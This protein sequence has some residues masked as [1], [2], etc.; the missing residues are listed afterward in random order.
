MVEFNIN[1]LGI[2]QNEIC[3]LAPWWVHI[4]GLTRKLIV[5]LPD[6]SFDGPSLAPFDRDRDNFWYKLSKIVLTEASPNLYI[7]RLR[8]SGEILDEL[9]NA[10]VDISKLTKK[11]FL[12]ECNSIYINKANGLE[13]LQE[14]F[15]EL[16]KR[17]NLNID[18]SKMLKE[19]YQSFFES[20]QKR[21]E[22]LIKDGVEYAGDIAIFKKVFQQKNGITVSTIHGIKGAEFDTVI[23]VGLL[24]DIV[25]HFNDSNGQDSAKKQLYV[26]SS[27]ARK[28]LHLISERERYKNFGKPP[29]EYQ[30]TRVLAGYKFGYDE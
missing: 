17:L 24:E 8:W 10:G 2:H 5:K 27:R 15:K 20:S 6:Y 9:H 29:P 19:H 7:R 1:E 3:I 11:I 4:I 22:R 14:F 18:D 26:V 25:P 23:A 30:T 13:Y 12:K 28:N 16:F 21:I